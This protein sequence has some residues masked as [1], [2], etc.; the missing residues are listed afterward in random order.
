MPCSGTRCL[1]LRNVSCAG[2]RINRGRKEQLRRSELSAGGST[3][4]P[5]VIVVWI[6]SFRCIEY[7]KAASEAQAEITIRVAYGRTKHDSPY[8]P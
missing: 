7:E 1:S 3:K 5:L 6:I 8:N 2:L 4:S